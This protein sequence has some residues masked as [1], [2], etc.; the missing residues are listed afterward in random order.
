MSHSCYRCGRGRG[1][2]AVC[3]TSPKY[4][5]NFSFS[6]CRCDVPEQRYR[7]R[8]ITV[9][10]PQLDHNQ[11]EQSTRICRSLGRRTTPSKHRRHIVSVS[12]NVEDLSPQCIINT[13]NPTR[14]FVRKTYMMDTCARTNTSPNTCAK[15][16]AQIHA[17]KSAT[18]AMRYRPSSTK[19]KAESTHGKTRKLSTGGHRE[20]SKRNRSFLNFE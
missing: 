9:S 15:L 16:Q 20:V 1:S 17:K 8:R 2:I 4:I 14:T 7:N 18:S 6:I 10:F 5:E 13:Q 3:D 11:S 12:N 19:I